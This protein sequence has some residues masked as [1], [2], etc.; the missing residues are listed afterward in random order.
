MGLFKKYFTCVM[1]FFMPFTYVIFCQF[2]FITS[3]VLFIKNN[4]LWNE[5]KKDFSIYDC[6]SGSHY[7]KGNHVFRHNCVFRR[8]YIYINNPCW[9]VV[10]LDFFV[11][12]LHSSLR[13]SGRLLD[14]LFLLLAVI[15]SE[16]HKKPTRKDRVTE[17]S[18]WK[19]TD[20]LP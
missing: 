10:E 9:Q 4:K 15:W 17:T 16:L 7:A 13:Y 12:M 11:Q 2:N 1:A 6:F 20:L 18:T 5:R 8:T 19:K 3:P 14:V